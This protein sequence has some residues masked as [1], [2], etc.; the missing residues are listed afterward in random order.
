M[1]YTDMVSQRKWSFD[2]RLRQLQYILTSKVL[3]KDVV[4]ASSRRQTT[5]QPPTSA[6]DDDSSAFLKQRPPKTAQENNKNLDDSSPDEYVGMAT[7]PLIDAAAGGTA[8][9]FPTSPLKTAD[10][11]SIQAVSTGYPSMEDLTRTIIADNEKNP[12]IEGTLSAPECAYRVLNGGKWS[13]LG[14]IGDLIR[15]KVVGR[16]HLFEALI[17]PASPPSTEPIHDYVSWDFA[18]F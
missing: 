5:Q 16:D 14:E 9:I 7:N 8:G 1:A 18:L 15:F 11:K 2:S 3:L 13:W 4:V 12:P 17:P 6:D 10:S